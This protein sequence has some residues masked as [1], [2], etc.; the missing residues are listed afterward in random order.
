MIDVIQAGKK[1]LKV[2]NL[3]TQFMD[4]LTGIYYDTAKLPSGKSICFGFFGELGYGLIS[5]FPYLKHLAEN[6]GLP[7]STIGMKGSS[8]FF[9]FSANHIE[10]P[11][12]QGDGWGDRKQA[13]AARR[14][15]SRNTNL[16]IPINSASRKFR[17]STTESEW[18]YPAIHR[19]C[20]LDANY[21]ELN[22]EFRHQIASKLNATGPYEIL[23]VKSHY[24]WGTTEIP[25]F[26]TSAEIKRL[27]D[28]SSA[29]GR[30]LYLNRFPAPVEPGNLPAPDLNVD[31]LIDGTNILDLAPIYAGIDDLSLKN[32]LQISLLNSAS[33]IYASQGGNAALSIIAGK[34]VSVLM[35]GGEDWP[36]YKSLSSRYKSQV[37]IVYEIDQIKLGD[38]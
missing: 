37:E 17:F 30:K 8:P 10:L 13:L 3:T 25:N 1:V 7:F 19:D 27:S 12:A 35:R 21:S 28:L 9:N 26:Y 24:N 20:T 32:E 4:S 33:H 22:Y 36:D 34:S 14:Y 16:Y 18:L 6:V 5:F 29:R 38:M 15:I 2:A 11:I 23:N 31:K